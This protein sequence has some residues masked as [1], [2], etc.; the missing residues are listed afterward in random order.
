MYKKKCS[1]AVADE[2]RDK[3]I[4][5]ILNSNMKEMFKKYDQYIKNYINEKVER[6]VNEA[7]QKHNFKPYPG[8]AV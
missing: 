8:D 5:D 3:F 1:A 2:I 4:I 7:M 6:R